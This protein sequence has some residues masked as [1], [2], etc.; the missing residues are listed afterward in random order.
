MSFGGEEGGKIVY[1]YHV[2]FFSICFCFSLKLNNEQKTKQTK[3]LYLTKN[4]ML[5]QTIVYLRYLPIYHMP[6]I[7]SLLLIIRLNHHNVYSVYLE[8]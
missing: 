6:V 3:K 4:K 1:A 5:G 8:Y 2:G 7:G